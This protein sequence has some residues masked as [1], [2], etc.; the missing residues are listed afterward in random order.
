MNLTAVWVLLAAV[1]APV[2]ASVVV[3]YESGID[4]Y[5]EAVEGLR[6]GLGAVPFTIVDLRSPGGS[7]ELARAI[8]S[9]ETRAV[10]AV[11]NAALK[12][13]QAYRPGAPVIAALVLRGRETELA[14]AHVELDVTLA[15]QLA[16]MKAIL[17]GR[18]RAGLI[19]N[20][21]NARYPI[22][23]LE[24][25]ARREGYTLSSVACDTPSRLLKAMASLKGHVDFVLCTPDPDFY[26][27]VTIKPLVMA[28]LEERLPLVGFS[29]AFVR[30]GALAGIYPDYRET[31][32]QAADLALRLMKN[33]ER[34]ADEGPSK[35]RVAVNQRVARLLGIEFRTPSFPLEV[36]R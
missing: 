6:T 13:V 22:E 1:L 31:G 11:G 8:A 28:S 5:A 10:V 16:A 17:P 2:Q 20:P 4:A 23:V 14:S 24:A 19:Y 33:G 29:P 32:R 3:A 18:T 9:R 36:F 34:P 15:I 21:K 12:N 7:D 35:V 30:A 25:R 26:N 27:P